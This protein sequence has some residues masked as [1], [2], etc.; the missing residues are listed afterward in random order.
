MFPFLQLPAEIRI[1]VYRLLLV[2]GRLSLCE[3]ST[4]SRRSPTKGSIYL[5]DISEGEMTCF[6]TP[7]FDCGIFTASLLSV[8]HQIR[9]EAL[10]IFFRENIFCLCALD[11]AIPFFSDQSTIALANLK[12]IHLDIYL[13]RTVEEQQALKKVFDYMAEK[14]QLKVLELYFWISSYSNRPSVPRDFFETTIQLSWISSLTK[15]QNLEQLYPVTGTSYASFFPEI[16]TDEQFYEFADR[17]GDYLRSKMLQPGTNE[18]KMLNEGAYR[19][20]VLSY[21]SGSK[22]DVCCPKRIA[23]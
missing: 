6:L 7:L 2:P 18:G 5:K 23:N 19:K 13:G 3:M 1:M 8:N 16:R 4:C 9:L 20:P 12:E 15:I 22:V 14:L 17:L 10:P 11:A 21:F